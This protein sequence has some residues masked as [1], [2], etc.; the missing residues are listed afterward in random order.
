MLV[1]GLGKE[2]DIGKIGRRPDNAD[3]EGR[4]SA[5]IVH[6][7]KTGSSDGSKRLKY[8]LGLYLFHRPCA[9]RIPPRP[10]SIA[11]TRQRDRTAPIVRK[12]ERHSV[13]AFGGHALVEPAAAVVGD[14]LEMRR[15]QHGAISWVLRRQSK[16]RRTLAVPRCSIPRDG[17]GLSDPIR[18]GQHGAQSSAAPSSDSPFDPQKRRTASRAWTARCFR[19]SR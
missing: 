7:W 17:G 14:F 16:R 5:C 13:D 3:Q 11:S 15:E 10:Q 18:S 9:R 19:H 8:V 4:A 12:R 2:L 1:G 6:L